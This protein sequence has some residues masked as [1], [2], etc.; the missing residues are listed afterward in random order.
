MLVA[1]IQVECGLDPPIKTFEGDDLGESRLFTSAAIFEAAR[2][3]H[4]G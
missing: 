2:E 3:V 4:E 1:G